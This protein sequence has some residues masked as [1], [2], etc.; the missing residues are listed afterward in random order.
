MF[1]QQPYSGRDSGAEDREADSGHKDVLDAWP[2]LAS[3]S[4]QSLPR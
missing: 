4:R 3:G 1:Q 2:S